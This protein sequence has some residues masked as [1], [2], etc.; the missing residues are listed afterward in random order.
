MSPQKMIMHIG[1]ALSF[2]LA[3]GNTFAFDPAD[4]IPDPIVKGS[5]VIELEFISDAISPNWLT[6]AG[7]GTD[8]LFVVEQPGF[9]SIIE[10]GVKLATPFLDVSSR[11]PALGLFGLDFDERG[12]FGL[13]FHPDYA[14]NGKLYTFTSEP[15]TARPI[16][17]SRRSMRFPTKASLPNGWWIL[18][19]PIWWIQAREKSS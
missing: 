1:V 6:H 3:T 16:S 4:P 15:I 2:A 9:I 8:R 13:A 12:L 17:P 18:V 10:G 7:D 19:T 14:T 11:L 5:M